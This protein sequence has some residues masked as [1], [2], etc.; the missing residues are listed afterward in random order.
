MRDGWSVR[1]LESRILARVFER[2][3]EAPGSGLTPR[4]G[5]LYTYRMVAAA[6]RPR[7]DLGFG[8][9]HAAPFPGAETVPP[10]GIVEVVR[11][12]APDPEWYHLAPS[13]LGKSALYTY[14]AAVERVVDGDTLWAEIDGG[15]DIWVR[16]KRRLR[17]IDAPEL[18]REA[19]RRVRERVEKRVNQGPRVLVS[20]QRPDKYGRYLADLFL[21]DG[22]FLNG[23]LVEQGEAVVW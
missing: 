6:H 10:G 15:F 19:G 21:P 4:R 3:E 22:G 7:L 2:Q 13:G 18:S 8:I 1:R 11:N 5:Q 16:Q 9:Y 23:E 17:G 20:T 14:Q 12:G